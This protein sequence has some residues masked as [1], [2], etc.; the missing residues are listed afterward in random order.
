MDEEFPSRLEQRLADH[1]LTGDSEAEVQFGAQ[2]REEI[3]R[4]IKGALMRQV[5]GDRGLE[6]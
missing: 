4:E 2:I 5:L 1:H 6:L 3:A